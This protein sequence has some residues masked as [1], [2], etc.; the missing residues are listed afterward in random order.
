MGI[1]VNGEIRC[2][3]S[4]VTVL[5]LVEALGIRPE[6]VVV[7]RNLTIVPREQMADEMIEDGDSIE[8]IRL[9]GGG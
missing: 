5:A 6:G 9:V 2:W 1:R 7:E 4:P 3:D 8:I